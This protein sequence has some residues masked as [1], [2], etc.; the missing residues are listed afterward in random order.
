MRP[1]W[2][3]KRRWRQTRKQYKQLMNRRRDRD[4]DLDM[5]KLVAGMAQ[6]NESLA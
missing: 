6:D 3:G 4:S 5:A 1:V 2:A